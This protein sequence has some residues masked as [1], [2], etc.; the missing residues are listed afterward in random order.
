MIKKNYIQSLLLSLLVSMQLNTY[1]SAQGLPYLGQTLPGMQPVRFAPSIFTE[2]FHAPPI[3]SPD[4]TEV[5]WSLMDAQYPHILHMKLENGEWSNPAVASFCI[6]DYS[7]SPFITS[8]GTKLFFLSMSQPAY[9]EG[10]Y[11]VEKQNGQWTTPQ[12]LGNEV[13]QFN[14]HWQTSVADNRPPFSHACP[15]KAARARLMWFA[16]S[17]PR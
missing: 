2:E 11:M 1:L 6:G 3:F 8:D 13:N 15:A 5:F 16:Q 7:D 17:W 14:P 4:G 9:D 10:I 12:I